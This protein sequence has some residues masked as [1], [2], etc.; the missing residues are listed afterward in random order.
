[1]TFSVH[2]SAIGGY[3]IGP[4]ENTFEG[5]D[6]ASA[7]A[8]RDAYFAANPTKLAAYDSNPFYLI[9]LSYP[10]T[11]RAEYRQGGQWIDYTPFLQGLPGE[12]A[13]LVNVPVGEVPYK[14]IDGTF[15]GSRLRVLDN[16]SLLAPP[17]FGVESGSVNFGDALTL[18]ES[19]GFLAIYNNIKELPFTILD[20]QTPRDGA[21]LPPYVFHLTEAE[22]DFLAQPVFTTTITTNPLSYDYAVQNTARSNA[23][24]FKAASPMSNVRIRISQ[25]SNGVVLK[26]IPT[27]EAWE[28]GIGGLEWVAGDNTFDFEDTPL[29]LNTGDLIHF[30]FESSANAILG[31]ASGHAYIRTT[32]Q[33]GQF[34]RTILANEYTATNVRDK[35]T[36]LTGTD[37]LPMSAVKDGVTSVAGRIGDVVLTADDVSGLAPVATSGAYSS[38]TGLPFIPT[39]TNQLTNGANFIT[40]SQAPVQSVN[41][42]TGAVS[43]VKS[44]VGLGNVDNTSDVNKPVSVAQQTAIDLKMTQHNAAVD[45]H[46]QYTTTAEAASA[47]PVQSVNGLTGSVVLT[48]AQVAESGNLYYTDAR[49]QT[50]VASQ[51]GF[52]V[53]SAS[54][55]G[56][57]AAV[58]STNVAGD[59]RFRSIVGSGLVTVTQ[60]TNDITI[61]APTVTGGTYTPTVTNV[62]GVTS[63]SV[64]SA[65][66]MR[67]DGVVT[68][69]GQITVDPTGAGGGA[70]VS[71]GLSLPVAS[72][73]A[74]ANECAGTAVSPGVV[75]QCGAIS[76]D[77]TNDRASFTFIASAGSNQVWYYQYTYRII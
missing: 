9:R 2:G 52:N 54:S 63:S 32:L 45:P 34:I 46:P 36:S 61:A 53:K 22:G 60:G 31:D 57:G 17:G 35:L 70:N 21:S 67:V 1:M 33:Q 39:N 41:G 11:T 8:A 40:A 75:G 13:S 49:V 71:I 38:L 25:V 7:Q 19:A 68:V 73:F 5:A 37:R 4:V 76:A 18:S 12:V 64:A 55:I 59:L 24:T 43:L 51:G 48:T 65:Q 10:D 44:D 58:Y 56:S 29:I 3:A 27:K 77:A 26:Y 69:S 16:G 62:S 74:S 14:T 30:D 42:Y 72:N 50:Y 6:L 47:A 15:S 20:Y 66:W 23:L 28:T